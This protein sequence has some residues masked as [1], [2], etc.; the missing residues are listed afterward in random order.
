MSIVPRHFHRPHNRGRTSSTALETRVFAVSCAVFCTFSLHH[1]QEIA[2]S[3]HAVTTRDCDGA[4]PLSRACRHATMVCAPCAPSAGCLALVRPA[5][6]PEINTVTW[7]S[8][9][10]PTPRRVTIA[11][12]GNPGRGTGASPQARCDRAKGKPVL[13]TR[14]TNSATE[15]LGSISVMQGPTGTAHQAPPPGRCHCSVGGWSSG[16]APGE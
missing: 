10:R 14:C 5:S 9:P 2:P 8:L 4:V 7:A 3:P 1:K 12:I 13:I 15:G 11:N 6:A 16:V